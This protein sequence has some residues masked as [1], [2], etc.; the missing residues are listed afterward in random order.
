VFKKSGPGPKNGEQY[1]A[2]F[3]E[4]D[5]ADDNVVDFNVKSAQ[6]EAPKAVVNTFTDQPQPLAVINA[7][8]DQLQPLSDDELD[9]IFK[10]VFDIEPVRDQQHVNGYADFPQVCDLPEVHILI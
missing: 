4:E 6:L 1:G 10:G 7:S 2:P 5:W 8:T 9:E 3:R